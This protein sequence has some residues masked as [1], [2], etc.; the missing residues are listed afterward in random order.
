MRF[1][2]SEMQQE[3][4]RFMT[5]YRNSVGRL[6]GMSSAA[7]GSVE[8]VDSTLWQVVG[9]MYDYGIEGIAHPGILT[10][11]DVICRH[12]E[13]ERFL[14]ALETREMRL[15]LFAARIAPPRLAILT[16]KCSSARRVLDGGD[17]LTDYAVDDFGPGRGDFGYLTLAEIA[18]LADMDERSVRNAANPKLPDHLRTEQVG[19]RSLVHPEEGR[20]WLM[21]RKRFV[22][23][24]KIE[25][26]PQEWRAPSWA[27]ELSPEVERLHREARLKN[28]PFEEYLMGKILETFERVGTMR[29]NDDAG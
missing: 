13:V 26:S 28:V 27:M 17:R 8:V 21:K 22:P 10:S 14:Y 11:P 16:A 20:R 2:K 1:P 24:R 5:G 19:R 29:G 15:F 3:L 12:Q 25:K 6:L 9:E 4:Q 18:M 7:D 23:T